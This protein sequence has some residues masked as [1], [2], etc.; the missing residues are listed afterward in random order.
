MVE[1]GGEGHHARLALH[2]T[3]SSNNVVPHGT[4]ETFRSVLLPLYSQVVLPDVYVRG[5]EGMRLLP[6]ADRLAEFETRYSSPTVSGRPAAVR[7]LTA[8]TVVR[9]V[10]YMYMVSIYTALIDIAW[11]MFLV[12]LPHAPMNT[13]QHLACNGKSQLLSKPLQLTTFT[14]ACSPLLSRTLIR[15]S[16]RLSAP[17]P[18]DLM[19]VS[20]TCSTLCACFCACRSCP[21]C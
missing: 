8:I 21:C 6:F 16:D 12:R 14:C 19:A 18:R 15:L 7:A 2:S 5:P 11:V 20:T 17:I 9:V 1:G 4:H 10:A 13:L 3:R